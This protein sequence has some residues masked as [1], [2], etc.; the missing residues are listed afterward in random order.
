MSLVFEKLDDSELE[1]GFAV[2][3]KVGQWLESQGRRQRI[4]KTTFE[5]YSQWQIEKSNFAVKLGERIVGLV[6]LRFEKLEDWPDVELPRTA[7]M[8][9]ALATDPE[10]QGMGVGRFALIQALIPYS[11]FPRTID[12]STNFRSGTPVY[13]DCVS[14]TLPGYYETFG[15]E[16]LCRHLKTFDDGETFDVTL[17]RRYV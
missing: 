9:R 7:L 8:I 5:T 3:A 1:D 12:L 11:S 10:F 17:M 6:T 4:S 16:R 15:F 14:D 13:L 2:L